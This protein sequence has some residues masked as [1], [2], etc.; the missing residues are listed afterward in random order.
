MS[1]MM[2]SGGAPGKVE[3]LVRWST[4]GAGMFDVWMD[5]LSSNEG[6]VGYVIIR[7]DD[8]SDLLPVCPSVRLPYIYDISSSISPSDDELHSDKLISS[9]RSSSDSPASDVTSSSATAQ[10]RPGE[11]PSWSNTALLV[12]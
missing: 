6:L 5:Q 8:M 1:G 9:C 12:I 2:R 10:Y 4:W 3:Q 11:A 7:D